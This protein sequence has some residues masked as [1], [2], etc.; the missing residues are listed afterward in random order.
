MKSNKLVLLDKDYSTKKMTIAA[1]LL[2]LIYIFAGQIFMVKTIIS[3][4]WNSIIY[5]LIV[6]VISVFSV[7]FAKTKQVFQKRLKLKKASLVMTI[8]ALVVFTLI[9]LITKII[10]WLE[11]LQL[12]AVDLIT[13]IFIALGAGI[14]EEFLLRNLAFNTCLT[15]FKKKRYNIFLSSITSSA[16]FGLLHLVNLMHQ[17]WDATS[18]QIFYAFTLGLAF[19]LI[20]IVTNNMKV[21][22][23]LHFLYDLTPMIASAKAGVMPWVVVL[24]VFGPI[25]VLSLISLWLINR[26]YLEVNE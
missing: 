18:E 19:M 6:L 26:R 21:T 17:D 16:I 15:Y 4:P 2:V 22:P 9:F 23:V 11:V 8:I 24:S 10:G 1:I 14:G 25:L 7:K 5:F 12:P 13:S 20:H 3:R